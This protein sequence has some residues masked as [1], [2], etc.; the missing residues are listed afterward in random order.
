MLKYWNIVFRKLIEIWLPESSPV[1]DELLNSRKG[2]VVQMK[3]LSFNQLKCV[4]KF[5]CEDTIDNLEQNALELLKVAFKYKLTRMIKVCEN[6]LFLNLTKSNVLN[7][8]VVAVKYYNDDKEFFLEIISY[9]I[10]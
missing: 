2:K 10:Q 6:S 7:T 4:Y 5:I 8:F 3:N 9:I 1:F